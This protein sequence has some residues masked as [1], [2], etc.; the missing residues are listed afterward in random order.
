MHVFFFSMLA[1]ALK[2]LLPSSG[3][4]RCSNFRQWWVVCLKVARYLK[5]R[6]DPDLLAQSIEMIQDRLDCRKPAG[7]TGDAQVQSDVEQLRRAAEGFRGD[8]PGPRFG[9]TK[10]LR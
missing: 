10:V 6:R 5:S 1:Q 3:T 4:F 9:D 2:K 8:V 7:S